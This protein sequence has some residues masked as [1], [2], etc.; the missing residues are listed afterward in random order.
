MVRAC[1]LRVCVSIVFGC[2]C[3]VV[4]VLRWVDCVCFPLVGEGSVRVRKNF[5]MWVCMYVRVSSFFFDPK[6]Q[7]KPKLDWICKYYLCKNSCVPLSSLCFPLFPLF[8]ILYWIHY[9]CRD[10]W[11][12]SSTFCVFLLI[13]FVF[14]KFYFSF[15]ILLSRCFTPRSSI[16]MLY[17][18]LGSTF[19]V[20]WIGKIF[21]T[22]TR[23]QNQNLL[24]APRFCVWC[25]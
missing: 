3:L 8:F 13:T 19:L 20:F 9:S 14:C 4:F 11:V 25:L 7:H 18:S 5:H 22:K 15:L 1:V 17:S 12:I 24:N 6:V 23:K 21:A 10:R 2:F 16:S